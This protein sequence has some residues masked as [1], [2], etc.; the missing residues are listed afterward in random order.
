MSNSPVSPEQGDLPFH[1]KGNFAPIFEERDEVDLEVSGSIPPELCGRFFRNGSNPQSGWSFHWFAGNGMVH[2]VRLEGGQAK[3]YRNRYVQTP[4]LRDPDAPRTSEDGVTDRTRSCANTHVISHGGKILAL[5]EGS[6]PYVLTNDLDTVGP[7][8]YDGKLVPAMTAHPT[9]CP[10]TG[11]LLFFGYSSLP[12]YL[13]YHRVNAAGE[14]VQSE[15]IAVT[16]PTMMHDFA[17]SR[18][19]AVFMDLPA[20]FDMELA[21]A[22]GMP[23]RWS[24]DYGARLGV[25]PR[26]GTNADVRWFEIDPCYVFHPMNAYVDGNKVVCVVGRHEYMWRDSMEDFAPSYLHRWTFDLDAGTV[27]EEQLD[28]VSHGF[29]RVDDRKVGLKN[30]YGWATAGRPGNE[31]DFREPD[32]REPNAR[33]PDFEGPG[34]LVK[35]DLEKDS[36][37]VHDFGPASQPGEFVFAESGPSAGEDEGWVMGFVYD[38]ERDASDLVILDAT[39]MAAKPAARIHLPRRIPH[40][41]HGSWIRS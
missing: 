34:V 26:G 15:E 18:N 1:L 16:G 27:S 6:F 36:S 22:G 17:V 29:P 5:E 3:W 19:H 23:I 7:N 4:L 14:L 38:M 12:P 10:E 8:N 28:D 39:D 32:F 31:P 35:Y 41:F 40:G 25:M 33:E 21:M 9:L 13:V 37:T 30:R 11:D 2:G 20:I 24:D